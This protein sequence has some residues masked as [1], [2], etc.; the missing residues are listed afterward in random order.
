MS[1]FDLETA[2][3]PIDD[4]RWRGELC[5]GWRIGEALNGGYV[6]AVA[7]RALC[8]ALPHPDP[9]TVTGYFL[10]PTS[11]GPVECLVTP[12]RSSRNTSF[13][14]LSMYQQEQP[15]LQVTAAYGDLDALQGEDWSAVERP[16]LPAF[17]DCPV[18]HQQV[19]ELRQRAEIR[20][21]E[22]AEIFS[23]RT[24]T[25]T[26][27]L[28][29]WTRHVDG[30]DPDALSLLMFADAFPPP[31]FSVFGP[32]HWVP[33]LELT[34]QVRARPAPGP[35]QVCLA[36]RHMT[37]GVIEEDGEFWDSDG[38]LVAISRQTARVRL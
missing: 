3:E 34:V 2:V 7:G 21:V 12:L 37:R 26:G 30:A 5:P 38:K 22:G 20:L 23:Q 8:E 13:A 25:G 18:T 24:T 19:V 10:N 17:E 32:R 35:L 29:G 15:V 1:Q 14:A 16:R 36:S 28:T 31:V 9:L 6:M 4:N 33:T 27:R 11:L